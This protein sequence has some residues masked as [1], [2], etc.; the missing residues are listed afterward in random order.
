MIAKLFVEIGADIKDLSKGI[1]DAETTLKRFSKNVNALGKQL[2]TRMTLPLAGIGA[3]VVKLA[4]DFESSFADIRKT[5]DASEIQFKD[6]EKGIRDLAKEVP[7]SVNELNRLAGVAGQLGVKS[8]DIVEFTKVMAML[9]DTT[10]VSG[11]QASL[12]IARFMN[13]MGTSQKEVSNVGSAIVALGNN[14]AS[15]ESEIIHI[16]T[17]LASFG[18][19]LKLS[20]ADVLA[21]ATA[22]AS[23]GGNAEA[24]S[25][26]FQKTAFTIRDAVLTGN[27]D[28]AVFAETAGMTIEEFSQSFKDDAGQAIVQFLRGLKNISDEGQSTTMVLDKLGLADQRLQREFGKVIA[29]LGQLDQAFGVARKGFVE[30][31]ALTDEAQKRYETFASQLGILKNELRDIGISFGTDLM[32]ILKDGIGV[33]KDMAETFSNMSEDT[34]KSIIKLVAVLGAT[35]PL[36]IAIGSLINSFFALKGIAVPLFKLL[37]KG[38]MNLNPYVRAIVLAIAGVKAVFELLPES[39][40][41]SI[42]KSIDYVKNG[43]KDM[44]KIK[45]EG[46]FLIAKARMEVAVSE[47]EIVILEENI[48]IPDMELDFTEIPIKPI[49]VPVEPEIKILDIEQELQDTFLDGTTGFEG[50]AGSVSGLNEN[51]QEFGDLQS[52]ATN[53]SVIRAYQKQIESLQAQIRQLGREARTFGDT[54]IDFG[55]NVVRGFVDSTLDGFFNAL[56]GVKN[57]NT[58]ELELRKMSLQEQQLA[59]EE[60]LANQEIDREEFN[61]RMALL[62]QELLDTETQIAQA[63]ENV[64][65]KSLR[66]MGDA[67][68]S[69]VKEALAELAKLAIISV[70]GKMLGLGTVDSASGLAKGIFD[71]IKGRRT[72]GFARKNSPYF[73]GEQGMELFIP[74]TAGTVMNNNDL[75]NTFSRGQ[76]TTQNIKLG[77]EF[78]INGTDLVLALSEAN[79]QLGR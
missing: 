20:E 24:S 2:T 9:G 78:K 42:T 17:S 38:F 41:E 74:N 6:I 14:F 29:N 32:P 77:G 23:S 51:I 50:I 28:L 21:F 27:E 59:L 65:K 25:T 56:I 34:R 16:G 12:S 33:V 18:S 64:F 8:R 36:M 19:S 22:I 66:N 47:P 49:Q 35:G 30:N 58:Q 26:A 48:V 61:L 62:N 76:S 31:T 7:T 52:R 57:F 73:V 68:K 71:K 45:L 1:G 63:R 39:V 72:G 60:S 10:D 13:I 69:F 15:M 53:P 11:E 70:I 4:S 43:F 40:Q 5:V 44:E 79:Y 54:M 37:I 55:E 46:G 67:V 3:G 75:M